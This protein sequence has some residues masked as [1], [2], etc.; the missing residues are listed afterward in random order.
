M[1]TRARHHEG[2]LC[3]LAMNSHPGWFLSYFSRHVLGNISQ[4]IV[5]KIWLWESKTISRYERFLSTINLLPDSLIVN[6][7]YTCNTSTYLQPFEFFSS[8]WLS[9][10]HPS[11]GTPLIPAEFVACEVRDK[12]TSSQGCFIAAPDWIMKFSRFDQ[13]P[14]FMKILFQVLSPSWPALVTTDLRLWEKLFRGWWTRYLYSFILVK[15]FHPVKNIA[16]HST[17]FHFPNAFCFV[18]YIVS[19]EVFTKTVGPKLTFQLIQYLK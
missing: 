7:H 8:L 2:E 10:L 17:S 13:L 5:R 6:Y 4:F 18:E 12:L 11:S 3:N 9:E 1:T 16:L 19:Y 14:Q 15:P